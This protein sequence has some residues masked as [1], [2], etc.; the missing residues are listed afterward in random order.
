MKTPLG[1]LGILAVTASLLPTTGLPQT[2][3]TADRSVL[4]ILDASGSMNAALPSAETRMAIARRAVKDVAALIPGEAQLGLR[5]YGSQSPRA[6]HNCEDTNVAVPFGP[7]SANAGQIV[8]AVDA[9]EAQ[10]YTPI[11]H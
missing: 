9:A 6:D 7:A 10:G 8:A 4:V 11:A 5:L 1:C 2:C 3:N